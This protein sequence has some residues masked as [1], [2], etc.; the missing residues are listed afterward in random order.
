MLTQT[1][2]TA[3]D[4]QAEVARIASINSCR[5][6]AVTLPAVA[7]YFT[8]EVFTVEQVQPAKAAIE[9]AIA[10]D[11]LSQI[12]TVGEDVCEFTLPDADGRPVTLSKLLSIGPV[13]VVSYRG[14]TSPLTIIT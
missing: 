10:V 13:V 9:S 11:I 14:A 12:K 2:P 5:P 8:T 3:S 7:E 1:Q 4:I 6:L